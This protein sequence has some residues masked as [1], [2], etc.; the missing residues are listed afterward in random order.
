MVFFEGLS[1]NTLSHTLH[2]AVKLAQAYTAKDMP[3]LLTL[4][5]R[6]PMD[7]LVYCTVNAVLKKKK[8]FPPGVPSIHN[9]TL[10]AG[11]R[12]W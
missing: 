2:I 9:A 12:V 6:R 10:C 3:L 4:D 7:G 8:H 11:A 5:A 1:I